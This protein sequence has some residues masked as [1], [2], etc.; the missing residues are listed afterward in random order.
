M[1][2]KRSKAFE[3]YLYTWIKC[4]NIPIYINSKK[5]GCAYMIVSKETLPFKY[6]SKE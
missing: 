3:P 5:G 2:I 1:I 6:V 4:K